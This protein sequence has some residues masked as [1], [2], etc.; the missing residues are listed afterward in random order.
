[1][2]RRQFIERVLRQI[3]GGMPS[4][5]AQITYSLVNLWMGDAI[6]VAAKQN[7]TESIKLD[8]VAYV[9]NSFYTTYKEIAITE[10]ENFVYR[11]T[12]PQIP[13]GIGANEG[14]ATL[15]FKGEEGQV[16]L[17]AIALS[18][19]QKA[20]YQSLRPIPNKILYYNEG[21]YI[22]AISTIELYRYTATVT[23]VSGG[24]STDLDSTINVPDDYFPVIVEYVKAQLLLEKAQPQDLSNDGVDNK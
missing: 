23:M 18:Q 13:V 4:D 24:D 22:Y 15:Q 10:D 3:Y 21:K 19:R 11:L 9:N 6:A 20:Y 1:M 16:S 12:L 5:D 2:T 7:Y 8:G 14:V 17:P